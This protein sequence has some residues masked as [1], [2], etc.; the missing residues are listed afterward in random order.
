MSVSKLDGIV[1]CLLQLNRSVVRWSKRVGVLGILPFLLHSGCVSLDE[2]LALEADLKK[3]YSRV[4][5]LEKTLQEVKDG[6]EHNTS[7]IDVIVM[8]AFC[9][10]VIGELIRR[11]KK[12]CRDNSGIC[13]GEPVSLALLS[14][15]PSSRG[16]FITLS[17]TQPHV[18]FYLRGDQETLSDMQRKEL[19]NLL[20]PPWLDQTH[21]LV[22]AHPDPQ[23]GQEMTKGVA[24]LEKVVGEINS[25]KFINEEG[26][27]NYV[28]P[29]VPKEKTLQWVFPFL[30]RSERIDAKDAPKN[31]SETLIRSVWVFR[32]D[33]DS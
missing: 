10:P 28:S 27:A 24:R 29:P 18:A 17:K 14:V 13:K 8:R 12:V 26:V 11:V 9:P 21:F 25:M 6:Q 15:D 3:I 1:S 19:R 30:N 23:E 7:T 4:S 31:S 22:V 2:Y 32:V 5:A 20:K 16:H 33:C